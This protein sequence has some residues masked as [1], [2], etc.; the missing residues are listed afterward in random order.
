MSN[1]KAHKKHT[2]SVGSRCLIY[3]RLKSKWFDGTIMEIYDEK[4]EEWLVVEYGPNAKTT[5]K[6]QR[7]CADIKPLPLD[8][9]SYFKVGSI[10]QIYSHLIADWCKGEVIEIYFDNEG[11]WLKVQYTQHDEINVCD[12]QRYCKDL[13]LLINTQSQEIMQQK[14]PNITDVIYPMHEDVVK[15]DINDMTSESNAPQQTLILTSGGESPSSFAIDKTGTTLSGFITTIFKEANDDVSEIWVNKLQPEIL[16]HI[17]TYLKHHNG[18]K[19]NALSKPIPLNC[20]NMTEI[21][22]HH[23]DATYIDSFPNRTVAEIIL[24]ANYLDIPSLLNLG[25]AKLGMTIRKQEE[26][27]TKFSD[28][29]R[30]I[31]MYYKMHSVNYFDQNGMGKFLQFI[32][33]EEFDNDDLP[34]EDEL[35]YHCKAKNCSY[36]VFDIDNFPVN[37][38]LS[39]CQQY[40]KTAVIFCILQFCYKCNKLPTIEHIQIKLCNMYATNQSAQLN[41][42]KKP[43]KQNGDI[44]V[45][46]CNG[47]SK[48]ISRIDAQISGYIASILKADE[49]T[50]TIDLRFVKPKILKLI[51]EYLMQCGGKIPSSIVQPLPSSITDLAQ[52]GAD[53]WASRW[54]KQQSSVCMEIANIA[55]KMCIKPLMSLACAHIAALKKDSYQK[56]MKKWLDTTPVMD[57]IE[58]HKQHNNEVHNT[59]FFE[60]LEKHVQSDENLN[61]YS[62]FITNYFHLNDINRDNFL[63]Q[64]RESFLISILSY[65]QN[66]KIGSAMNILHQKME[67]DIKT[68]FDGH[69]LRSI[70]ETFIE[71]QKLNRHDERCKSEILSCLS[72]KRITSALTEQKQCDN[73]NALI[74]LN[75]YLHLLEYHDSD[76]EF[77]LIYNTLGPNC[78]L[79]NCI[80]FQRNYRQIRD[81]LRKLQAQDRI[82]QQ[83]FDKIHCYYYHSFDIGFRKTY[84]KTY[85][86]NK[87]ERNADTVNMVETKL[88]NASTTNLVESVESGFGIFMKNQDIDHL[89][90]YRQ[91]STVKTNQFHH[92]GFAI[93]YK[94]DYSHSHK[95]TSNNALVVYPKYKSLKDELTNNDICCI[96]LENFDAE[97]RKAN[98]HLKSYYCKKHYHGIT[99]DHLLSLMVYCNFDEMQYHFSKTYREKIGGDHHCFFYL[100]KYLTESVK[101][102]GTLVSIKDKTVTTFYHGISQKNWFPE[103]INRGLGICIYCPLSTSSSFEVA[104]NF[105]GPYDGLIVQF[106]NAYQSAAKYFDV[107]WISDYPNERECLFVQNGPNE[108]LSIDNIIIPSTNLELK[109]ILSAL[110]TFDRSF[111]L[112]HLR[113]E[114]YSNFNVTL[115]ETLIHHQLSQKLSSYKSFNSL[116]SYAQKLLDVYFKNK[117][118]IYL[119]LNY[120]EFENKRYSSDLN[121]LAAAGLFEPDAKYIL[122]YAPT[123]SFENIFYSDKESLKIGVITMLFPYVEKIW[124]D[125][126]HLRPLTIENI[127]SHLYSSNNDSKLRYISIGTFDGSVLAIP[128]AIKRYEKLFNIIKFKITTEHDRLCIYRFID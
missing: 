12:I 104:A 74:L 71:E 31:G 99:V 29:D 72:L 87:S 75:D 111:D 37:H 39:H 41:E 119:S 109:S 110:N 114:S 93:E 28:M 10:C 59:V 47:F 36:T 23:W 13:K 91:L 62:S 66:D 33:Q 79:R 122:K 85:T 30:I 16:H 17:I 128:E 56:Q 69:Q 4:H 117:N 76:E 100:G 124:V 25:C 9:P 32:I 116:D 49:I 35:G 97:L 113:P 5:K 84:T 21:V 45:L 118:F 15:T 11:E 105:A 96:S 95:K 90:K 58:K 94:N 8:H 83:L 26:V 80:S 1:E 70:N 54:I 63:Q 78:Q 38:Q 60:H 22:W 65:L 123:Y 61:V 73:Q 3:S 7:N 57:F 125:R 51:V 86:K 42:I 40:N 43:A 103:T 34:I 48:Q 14:E 68:N 108:R 102:F 55:F 50:D 81:S 92:F 106:S 126:I 53:E 67:N 19:P 101:Y 107:A 77:W 127:L 112:C 88:E 64:K 44:I 6:I 98:I 89:G 82:I 2:W 20:V 18:K 52:C 27:L 115:I 120:H 121:Q 46:H 24:A